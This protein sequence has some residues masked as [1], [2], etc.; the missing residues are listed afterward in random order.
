[1]ACKVPFPNHAN[2]PSYHYNIVCFIPV[3][4]NH[5]QSPITARA[6]NAIELKALSFD[7]HRPA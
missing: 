2:L 7:K 3:S 5:H 1:M 6:G 4:N